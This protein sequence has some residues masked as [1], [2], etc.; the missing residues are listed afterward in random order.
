MSVRGPKASIASKQRGVSDWVYS[1]PIADIAKTTLLTDAV[2][3]VV[4]LVGRWLD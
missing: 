3:K 2:E 4:V 1:G